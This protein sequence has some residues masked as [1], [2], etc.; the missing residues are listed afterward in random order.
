MKWRAEGVELLEKV[1]DRVSKHSIG[2]TRK[3]PRIVNVTYY[4]GVEF[5]LLNE[6]VL[7][8]EAFFSEDRSI[9][10]LSEEQKKSR[11][12]FD[13][14]LEDVELPPDVD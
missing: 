6:P 10:A 8:Y 3:T 13:A 4:I 7:D 11:N 14:D 9:S 1:V 12:F 5:L 2:K